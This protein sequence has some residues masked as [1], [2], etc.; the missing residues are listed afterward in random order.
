MWDEDE[1]I[2]RIYTSS[3][4]S[5]R[6]LEKLCAEYPGEY[7]RTFAETDGEDRIMAAKYEVGCKYIRFR[8][9]ASEAMKEQGRIN[10]QRMR[11]KRNTAE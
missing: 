5:I 1:K 7:R 9:P 11:E 2:A 6:K 8:K 10:A 3:P 4:V